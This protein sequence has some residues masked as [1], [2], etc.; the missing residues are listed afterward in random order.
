M[1]YEAVQ[2]LSERITQNISKVIIGKEDKIRLL[3]IALLSGG[4]ILL[5][6]IPGTGKTTLVKAL[7]KSLDADYK[8]IQFTPD[9][10]PA[11]I[12]GIHYFNMKTSEF[13]FR[14]GPVFTNVLLA[15]ELN[16]TAPRTQSALLEC[17][18]EGQTTVDGETMP[19][20]SPFFVI[21]TENPIENQGTFPLPEAQLDR[22]FMKI[23]MGYP[24]K[25]SE[26]AILDRYGAA[27]PMDALKPVCTAE[28]LSAAMAQLNHMT[29][30]EQVKAYIVAIAEAT[31]S[32]ERILLGASPRATLALMRVART[33]AAFNGRDYVLPDDVKEM[34]LPV[35][36]HR[37]ILRSQRTIRSADTT[38]QI[39][40]YLLEKVPVPL[41]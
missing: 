17:M 37:M 19:L 36:S 5:D 7:A 12:T 30:S 40:E 35:L 1:Y 34:A 20:S 27:D 9:L 16:R 28:E 26:I 11:D 2:S 33:C 18:Q 29:V 41:G 39:L 6:D 22:F 3:L 21:A 25:A 31:R 4:H 13:V 32:N 10:L 38:E 15:D 8:R 23:S 14:A 24:D